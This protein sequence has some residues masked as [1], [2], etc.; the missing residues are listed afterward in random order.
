[1]RYFITG[2]GWIYRLSSGAPASCAGRL[3]RRLRRIDTLLRRV[4]EGA[5]PCH[6]VREFAVQAGGRHDGRCRQTAAGSAGGHARCC[7]ASAAQAGVRYSLENPRAYVDANLVGSFN[8]LEVVRELR[9]RHVDCGLDQLGLRCQFQ[10]SVH[11]DRPR[12]RTDDL[13][14][15][16]KKAME[17]MAHAYAH[18]HDIPTT[19]VRF[20]TVYGPWGRPDM[21]LFKFVSAALKGEAIDVYGEGRMERDSP[22]VDDLVEAIAR[23]TE[24]VPVQGRPVTFEGGEDSLSPIAPFRIG[25]YRRWRAGWSC[26][27]LSIRSSGISGRR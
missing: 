20:F 15:A 22:D 7:R 8:L 16:S 10:E 12:G 4:A 27:A 13:Y 5:P 24:I 2:H 11:R 1:M 21:A 17:A 14:A 26:C 23:L 9:V 25:Q 18:L 19:A 6:P 3:R